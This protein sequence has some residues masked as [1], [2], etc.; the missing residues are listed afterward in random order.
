ML[1]RAT[2]PVSYDSHPA[3]DGVVIHF[4]SVPGESAVMPSMCVS[5]CS[6]HVFLISVK[7]C[8]IDS[9]SDEY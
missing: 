6:M 5:M 3:T 1:F 7:F 9:N 8:E 2:F 4:G